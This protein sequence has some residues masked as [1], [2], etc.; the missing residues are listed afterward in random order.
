MNYRNVSVCGWFVLLFAVTA[1]AGCSNDG[2]SSQSSSSGRADSAGLHLESYG[3][4]KSDA[5]RI[6]KDALHDRLWVLSLENVRVYDI[7]RNRKT[8]L[9]QIALPKWSVVPF[10]FACMPD[11]AL[12]RFGSAFISSN[13][14]PRIWRIDAE[15]FELKEHEIILQGKEQW[16]LGFGALAFAADGT[17]LALS[18]PVGLLWSVDVDKASARIVEQNASFRDVCELTMQLVSDFEKSGKS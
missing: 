5:L 8:L 2:N 6:R 10:D 9:R 12:D 14:Q 4:D 17:L 7:A 18:S 13:A 11:M 3:I 15:S 16:D 1:M